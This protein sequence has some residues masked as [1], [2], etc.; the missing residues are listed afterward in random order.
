MT[1]EMSVLRE[2]LEDMVCQFGYHDVN[3]KGRYFHTV[4]LSSLEKAFEALGWDDP[5]YVKWGGCEISGCNNWAA[6]VAAYPRSRARRNNK[7]AGFGFLCS[8]H[9]KEWNGHDAKPTDDMGRLGKL[10]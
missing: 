1:E 6:C 10:A 5:H 3:G 2:A 4:G 7:D 8:E 9:Y